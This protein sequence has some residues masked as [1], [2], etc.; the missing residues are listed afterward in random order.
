ML[1]AKADG[2]TVKRLRTFGAFAI[3]DVALLIA[4]SGGKVRGRVVLVH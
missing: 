3:S 1:C 2:V 4:E